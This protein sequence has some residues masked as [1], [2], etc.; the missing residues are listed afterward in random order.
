MRKRRWVDWVDFFS[1]QTGGLNF[2]IE[3]YNSYENRAAIQ[4]NFSLG[5]EDTADTRIC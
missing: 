5:C 3:S 1:I 2:S 4:T